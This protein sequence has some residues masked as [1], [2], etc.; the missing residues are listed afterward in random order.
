MSVPAEIE[1]LRDRVGEGPLFGPAEHAD[2]VGRAQAQMRADGIDLLVLFDPDSIAYFSGYS[3]VNLWDFA[4]VLI[5]A[6]GEPTVVLW[7]FELPRFEVSAAHGEARTYALGEDPEHVLAA[8]VAALGPQSWA[9]DEWHPASAA[10][11]SPR[12]R[13][14]LPPSARRDARRVLW[15]TR[16]V[17]SAA[18]LELLERAA[19]VTDLG[20]RAAHA[21]LAP[22][23][24]DHELAAAAAAAML[25]AGSGH[26]AIQPIVA[27]GSRAGVPHSEA[28]GA[29]VRPG[30]PVFLELGARL[31]GYTAPL[32]RTLTLGEPEPELRGLEQVAAAALAAALEAIRPGATAAT[33]A[34]AVNA[35]VA[36]APEILFHRCVGYPVGAASPPSWIEPLDFL[37]EEGNS[38]PLAADMVFHLP[39]SLR[40]RGLRGVGLSQTVR[41]TASGAEVLSSIPPTLWTKEN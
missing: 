30:Q 32:M 5:A 26:F 41:V 17:K 36:T 14:C 11:G 35:T 19:A 2:R 6:E 1:A 24:S 27:L 39:L 31:R 25:A 29:V 4:A 13:R 38:E 33:V 9:T 20:V 22:G 21:A 34:A 23:V 18:E 16:L 8:A 40:H 10:A 12:L 7:E 15:R 37:I 3:S 28:A